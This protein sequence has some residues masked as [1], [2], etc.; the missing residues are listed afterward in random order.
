MSYANTSKAY[1]WETQANDSDHRRKAS[2][3]IRNQAA[4]THQRCRSDLAQTLYLPTLRP[5][6]SHDRSLALRTLPAPEANE[7]D[8]L[9][10]IPTITLENTTTWQQ[11]AP[12]PENEAQDF[13]DQRTTRQP[14]NHAIACVHDWRLPPTARKARVL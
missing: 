3:P 6:A 8:S 2:V 13:Q 9:A 4:R 7:G 10:L 14:T 5:D 12:A 11:G 1:K